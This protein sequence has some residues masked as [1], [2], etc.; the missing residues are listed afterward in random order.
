MPNNIIM[1]EITSPSKIWKVSYNADSAGTK[2]TNLM[3]SG[4]FLDRNIGIE[5]NI[6]KAEFQTTGGTTEAISSGWVA[7][8]TLNGAGNINDATITPTFSN[9][10]LATYFDIADQTTQNISIT[11]QYTNTAGYISEHL[12]NVSGISSYYK[13]KMAS[14]IPGDGS[15]VLEQGNGTAVLYAETGDSD[16]SPNGPTNLSLDL[17]NNPPSNEVYYTLTAQGSGTVTGKGKG[18][19][20][21]NNAGWVNAN[22]SETSREDTGSQTSKVETIHKYIVK[23]VH[24][25]TITNSLPTSLTRENNSYEDIEIEPYGY[26][27]IPAGYNPKDRYVYSNKANISDESQVAENISLD[28]SNI[29]GNADVT[30][31]T[32]NNNKYPITANNLTVNG[33]VN[34]GTQGWF[35]GAQNLS[36]SA[37]NATV[38]YINKASFEVDE[39]NI[40]TKTAGYVPDNSIVGTIEPIDGISISGG[41]LEHLSASAN[42]SNNITINNTNTNNYNNGLEI[43]TVGTAGRAA[44][45]YSNPAGFITAHTNNGNPL[46]GSGNAI[47][48]TQFGGAHYYLKGVKLVAPS[49]GI[50]KFDITVPNGSTTGF[51]TFQFQVDTSGNVTVIG[52][53]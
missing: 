46:N 21:I 14:L 10:N 9:T 40:K 27:K 4:T 23:S 36:D 17:K 26:V 31:G 19:V 15:L 34:V 32:L 8:G 13:I 52:P 43:Q 29:I 5:I 42:F 7:A 41:N 1:T 16:N 20:T 51:I 50:A 11:P 6:P 47:L 33:T 12:S 3:T 39:N 35:S 53:D 30:I 28:I 44:I 24:G 48:P 45:T 22:T 38:G 49:S 18:T 2:I 37:I 25:N